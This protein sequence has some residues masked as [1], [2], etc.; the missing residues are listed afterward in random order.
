MPP[1][2]LGMELVCTSVRSPIPLAIGAFAHF[3]R[4]SQ[5]FAYNGR[6]SGGN[7]M[8]IARGVRITSIV[9]MLFVVAQGTWTEAPGQTSATWN[10]FRGESLDGR[11]Q[12]QGIVDEWPSQ[13]PPVLWARDLGV[14]YS[15]FVGNSGRVFTQYQS[16]SGQYVICLD[17]RTGKTIWEHRYAWPY[18]PASLYPGP[19]STPT[20][21]GERLLV[22]T[23]QARVLCLDLKRGTPIWELDLKK[24]FDATSVEFGYACSPV[25]VDGIIFLPV[26]GKDA[27]M[28]ALSESDGSVIWQSGND[29]ISYC[30]AYPIEFEGHRL[31]VG[32]FK[33]T[34]C[35]FDRKSGRQVARI[36][37]SDAYDEHSAWPI[38]HEPYLWV[39]GPF[40]A[41]SH[42][43]EIVKSGEDFRLSTVY[44]SRSMS[45][46]V[47]SSVLIDGKLYG[48]DLR[49]V[50]S[51]VHRPSRGQFV[52][53]DFM[54]G[55]VD[56]T[57][58]SIS[59]RRLESDVISSSAHSSSTDI[60][61]SSLIAADN[62]LILFNDVGELILCR[63][64]SD[65]F[66]QLAR[67]H[68][69]GGEI[70]WTQPTLLNRCVYVRNHSKAVCVYLG[71]L[72]LLDL[73]T[74]QLKYAS[75]LKPD[76]YVDLASIVLG[77]E[78][79]YAMTAPNLNWLL[80]WYLISLIVGW[81]VIP[82]VVVAIGS[83]LGIQS[84]RWLF[85][86]MLFV[87]GL[88]GTTL[89][90]HWLQQFYFSWP[91]ALAVVFEVLIC[92]INASR[93]SGKA[94]SWLPRV[95]LLIFVGIC[96]LFFWFCRRLSLAFEW[97]FLIGFP[98][99]LP[100]LW[101]STGSKSNSVL[102]WQR[103]A[104]SVLAFSAFYWAGAGII[105]WKYA[106]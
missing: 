77:T 44:K 38:Y 39:S 32:Y 79:K 76:Q 4:L 35:L 61:H 89:S 11:S 98:A 55:E 56:W 74:N 7:Q 72:D 40:R 47:A 86:G 26:G 42:L 80:R 23:P 27:S 67:T 84:A 51:K 83:I 53:M 10:F 82:A 52:C 41:G 102:T 99:A 78:P 104:I 70:C 5:L 1:S 65:E 64:Q 60:G 101:L 22:T 62:K 48:F 33:N 43:L 20:I 54:T 24:R 92:D 6:R 68:V 3:I 21:S 106:A 58:G 13:G 8:S 9:T 57:N 63:Q 28:V 96:G 105:L 29:A 100:I 50:Q 90:G 30:S 15:G 75:E 18:K 34:L 103:W 73:E 66:I 97:S 59:R 91:I 69:L 12:E 88:F 81:V 37:V 19:R 17:A 2:R 49:D 94:N 25:C 93:K 36:T 45:N 46:D 95:C 71:E 16:L 14:G 85:L 87:L 31:V